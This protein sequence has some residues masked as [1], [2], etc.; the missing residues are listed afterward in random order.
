[1]RERT[2]RLF[3]VLVGLALIALAGT[4]RAADPVQVLVVHSYSQEYPWTVGQHRGFMESLRADTS[5]A[6]DVRAEY[7]D[8]KRT[9]YTSAYA[10]LIADHLRAKYRGY[11]PSAIY[12]TD[13]NALKFALERLQQVFPGVPVFF[14]GVN[15]YSVRS[16]I[17]PAQ[18][19]G[20]FEKKE[21]APNLELM[22][23][24]APGMG[25]IAVVGDAS[26]THRAIEAEI[27][28]EL[29]RQPGIRARFISSGRIDEL[30]ARL[31]EQRS[32]FV[33]LTT[34]GAVTAADGRT[35][36]LPETIGAIVRAGAFVV[37]S[38]EDA[39]LFPG[40]LG[41]YVTSGP[42]QGRAAAGLMQRY[43]AGEPLAGLDPIEASP[44]EYIVDDVE[45]ARTGLS[46][47]VAVER[48]ATHVNV[49]RTFYEA[50]RPVVLGSLYGLVSLAV[51]GLA[52]A[53]YVYARKNREIL[54]AS[55][56]LTAMQDG[57][58]RAQ[59]MALMGNWDWHIAEKV[60]HW[61]DGV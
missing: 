47:P 60:L 39:Y 61:S 55:Q 46:L 9:G 31:R 37:F 20:V 43:F 16:R 42:R 36:T 41:G 19:T 40:V 3:A 22:K 59:R 25:D 7:L 18:V 4:A 13:D 6:Y 27:R 48:Q 14:S 29:E 52:A 56:R 1:M 5:R 28:A 53:L 51:L 11:R 57:L 15:D 35:L 23:S 33:F 26:E 44:N 32:H 45:L 38:M 21:I 2:I 54:A 8:T 30:V 50:N 34:L 58:D 17:D 49:Q 24:I 12:V 10:E